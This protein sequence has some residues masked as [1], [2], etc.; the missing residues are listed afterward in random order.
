MFSN[1]F[2]F[3]FG[4]EK[5]WNMAVVQHNNVGVKMRQDEEMSG[6]RL[7]PVDCEL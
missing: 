1:S 2:Q 3:F 5:Y 4:E 6:E 7:G